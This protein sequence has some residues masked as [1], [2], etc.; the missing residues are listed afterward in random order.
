MAT[1]RQWAAVWGVSALLALGGGGLGYATQPAP[2]YEQVS[3]TQAAPPV[4]VGD[5]QELLTAEQ[6]QLL[7]DATGDIPTPSTVT[8]IQY[9]VFANNHEEPLDDVENYLRDHAPELIDDALGENGKPRDGVVIIGVGL[10]PRKAFAYGGDDV[11]EQLGIANEGRLEKIL[12]AMKED[13]KAGDIPAGLLKS[14][15]VALDPEGV[16]QWRYDEMKAEKIGMG[17]AGAGIGFGGGVLVGAGVLIARDDR[18][19]KLEQAREDHALITGE[20]LRLAQRLDEV[21]VRAH[22]LSSD[23]A[24]A[25]LRSDWAEVRDRFLALNDAVH[26]PGG[27]GELDP[28]DEKVMRDNRIRLE[29]AAESVRHVS[30]AEDNIDRMFHV[31]Q[32]DVEARRADLDRMREDLADAS[33][34]A[35]EKGNEGIRAELEQLDARTA[36]LRAE[37][38]SPGFVDDF[39]RLLEDYRGVLDHIRSTKLGK[40]KE[41]E[42]WRE[43]AVYDADFWYLNTY[44]YANVSSWHSANV[45]AA[46]AASA[47]ASSGFSAAGGSSSF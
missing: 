23:F 35:R 27:I 20:Y 37:P 16:A 41:R 40:T 8:D 22:S 13:V 45:E 2:V 7:I 24:D 36:A 46:S 18:R 31:E 5:P 28:E 26:G 33:E 43:P 29:K 15:Q 10:D 6:E 14:A 9:L 38:S 47:S 21:D 4:A 42:K 3:V 17:V 34:E 30:H 44:T 39:L 19:K 11:G 32:G 1:N 25:Q 12:D